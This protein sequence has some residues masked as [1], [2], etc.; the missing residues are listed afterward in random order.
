MSDRELGTVKWFKDSKGYGFIKRDG[1]GDVFVHFSAIQMEWPQDAGERTTRRVL[2]RSR[3]QRPKEPLVWCPCTQR[4]KQDGQD[5]IRRQ[6]E[7]RCHR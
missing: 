4:R 5:C 2:R 3:L 7:S 6:H 1:G